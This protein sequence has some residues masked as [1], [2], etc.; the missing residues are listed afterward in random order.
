[1]FDE[2]R[3]TTRKL[4]T[5]VFKTLQSL[6]LAFCWLYMGGLVLF[7]LAIAFGPVVYGGL[8]YLN[9]NCC[10]IESSFREAME[11]EDYAAA[12]KSAKTYE[13]REKKDH[14]RNLKIHRGN[15]YQYNLF[16]NCP[17]HEYKY[18]FM[19]AYEAKGDYDKALEYC[20]DV[21]GR[22]YAGIPWL[23][24]GFHSLPHDKARI[25]YKKGLKEEAFRLY[26]SYALNFDEKYFSEIS[27][28][29][30]ITFRGSSGYNHWK[31]RLSCFR[32]YK[33]FLNFLD[34]EYEKL[35]RPEEYADAV[36]KYRAIATDEPEEEWEVEAPY[37][38]KPHAVYYGPS[39]ELLKQTGNTTKISKKN[40]K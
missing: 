32:T 9:P 16:K 17:P 15:S 12:I 10:M 36:E 14:A 34:E 5:T 6:F 37:D 4:G 25:L 29:Q 30:K 28:R 2:L 22:K 38:P 18:M 11:K 20:N 7:A 13:R 8:L 27:E 35:G 39:P 40:L 33:E 26:C 21:Y 24:G 3:K 1:M 31:T 19:Y 23:S